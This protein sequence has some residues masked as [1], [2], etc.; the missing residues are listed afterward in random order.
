MCNDFSDICILAFL[1]TLT[2]ELLSSS[3]ITALGSQSFDIM[4]DNVPIFD[5]FSK[6]EKKVSLLYRYVFM[7]KYVEDKNFDIGRELVL[8]K[9]L[10]ELAEGFVSRLTHVVMHNGN[11]CS[12]KKS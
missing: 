12:S 3:C 5:K 6:T 9:D 2:T 7:Y 1:V 10:K 4:C 8:P 11:Y